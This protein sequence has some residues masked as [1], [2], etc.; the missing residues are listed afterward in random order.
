MRG[1]LREDFV[2]VLRIHVSGDF[3]SAAYVSKW[4]KII[5]A[6]PDVSFF[7]YTRSWRDP[8]ILPGLV[9]LGRLP[10]M[11]LWW[12]LDMATG[13][14]PKYAHIRQA[15]MAMNDLDAQ[16]VPASCDLVFRVNPKTVMKNTNGVLVCP[17]ENMITPNMTCSKCKLCW[18]PKRKKNDRKRSVHNKRRSVCG[19]EEARN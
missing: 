7:A 16:N 2:R 8:K 14:A 13:P 3:Y 15:Y 18:R 5:A 10:N 1:L 11:Q 6:T 9:E 12:S 4:H 17:E 19:I